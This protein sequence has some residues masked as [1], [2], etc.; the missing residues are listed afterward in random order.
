VSLRLFP[1]VVWALD[2]SSEAS[3]NAWYE[4]L[5]SDTRQLVSCCRDARGAQNQ[6]QA[7]NRAT[8]PDEVRSLAVTVADATRLNIVV[9]AHASGPKPFCEWAAVEAH[10]NRIE[11][12]IPGAER[13]RIVLAPV[14]NE[15]E[16]GGT[17]PLDGIRAVPWLLSSRLNSGRLMTSDELARRFSELLDG[18]LLAER[19]QVPDCRSVFDVSEQPQRVRLFAFPARDPEEVLDRVCRLFARAVVF[20]AGERTPGRPH[21]PIETTTNCQNAVREFMDGRQAADDVLRTVSGERGL[22]GWAVEN[23]LSDGPALLRE[24][25]HRLEPAASPLNPSAERTRPLWYRILLMIVEFVGLRTKS[26]TSASVPVDATPPRGEID[27]V[28]SRLDITRQMLLAVRSLGDTVRPPCVI[29]IDALTEWKATLRQSIIGRIRE[30]TESPQPSSDPNAI[31]AGL[32]AAIRLVVVRRFV[33]IAN[34]WEIRDEGLGPAVRELA[35]GVPVRFTGRLLAGEPSLYALAAS[36]DL[37]NICVD[38]QRYRYWRTPRLVLFGVSNPVRVQ[39]L[40]I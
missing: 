7:F 5:D 38:L 9:V 22:G 6:A 30:V 31:S 14:E 13:I 19:L 15:D 4:Q 28:R 25:I 1:S 3:V 2:D 12:L 40:A 26:S 39:E 35:L 33:E 20:E 27:Y 10:L 11:R 24:L 34:A 23:L 16:P 29:P 17:V 36:N 21:P 32:Y 18:L 37:P 8:F